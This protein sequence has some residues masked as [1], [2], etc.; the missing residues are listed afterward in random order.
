MAKYLE[1]GLAIGVAGSIAIHIIHLRGSGDS[2]LGNRAWHPAGEAAW[3]SIINIILKPHRLFLVPQR[4]MKLTY[5]ST[6]TINQVD[7]YHGTPV[8]DP[9]RWLED[10]DSAETLDW[11]RRQNELTFGFLEQV[12]ARQGLK[13]RLTALWNFPRAQAPLKRGGRYFQ[14]RNSGLQNQDVLFVLDS[15]EGEARLLLDPNTLS[16]DGTV[17]LSAWE[18]SPDGNWLAYSTSA[19]GS[20][21]QTWQVRSVQSGQDLPDQVAWSKFSGAAWLKDGSGFFYSRYDAPLDGQEF[22]DANYYDKL[23]FH[24]LGSPQSADSLVYE[25]PD[26]RDWGFSGQVSDDGRY[27]LIFVMLG[28]DMRNRFFYRDLLEGGETV[29]L[30]DRLEAAYLFLGNDGPLFYFR[31]DLD[32]PR[33]RVIAIDIRRP[34]REDWREVIPQGPDVLESVQMVNDQFVSVVT[35]DAHHELRLHGLDG[36]PRGSIPLPALGTV[37]SAGEPRV[38][39]G[40]ADAELFFGFSSF[41][42]PLTIYRYD[43]AAQACQLLF[44]PPVD[45]NASAYETRQ[46]FVTSRDGTRVPL[47]LTHKKGLLADGHN[48][49]L[50]YG[51]GGFSVAMLPSFSL[52]WLAWLELGGVF[53]QAV[54]R[55]G[56]EYGEEWHQAGMLAN[57]QNVFDDFIACSEWLIAEQITSTPRLAIL[58]GSNG[59]LLVGACL[60]Q[61]PDLFGACLPAVGVMDMLRFQK[62]TIGWAWTSDYGCSDDPGQFRTL[63]AYSPLHNLKAG[64]HYPATM[65]TTADH[66]DRVV[67]GHSFKFAAAMQAA[68]AGDRPVLIRIQTK[69]GHGFGKPTAILIQELADRYAFL[70]WALGMAE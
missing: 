24:R 30:I 56:S 51:Y 47:F 63:L 49:T 58:G 17:A 20:D 29:E 43:F 45:F 61:R 54:L 11:I 64:S 9:Y 27:L 59:G 26:Q 60:T 23:Y 32:A 22:Q 15:L 65:V 34:A 38:N 13:E 50:L 69:A 14:L 28:T 31:T 21:W 46:V 35:H 3:R 57:K 67:P 7:D 42:F 37:M 48:P 2:F 53:A 66:D 19:S 39:A 70:I 44:S 4:P 8:A 6:R 10:V 62:F 40:R 33:G 52:G 12:P 68:Q 1:S 55:G 18:V 41:L 36:T 16:A 25:R 5:P